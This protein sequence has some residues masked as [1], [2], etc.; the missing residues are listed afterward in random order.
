M[1]VAGGR[2]AAV[3]VALALVATGCPGSSN[4]VPVSTTTSQPS[5]PPSAI[6]GLWQSASEPGVGGRLTDVS[7][8]PADCGV[9]VVSGD[10][11]GAARSEDGGTSWEHIDGLS[12]REVSRVTWDPERP[13][14]VWIATMSGPFRSDD[15]GRSATPARAGMPAESEFSYTVPIETVLFDPDVEGRLLA[16]G[17]SHR[18]WSSPPDARWGVVW[19]STDDGATWREAGEVVPDGVILAAIH[20]GTG[21]LA[22]VDDAGVFR[23]DDGLTWTGP[24]AGLDGRTVSQFLTAGETVWAAISTDTSVGGIASSSDGGLTWSVD[25]DGIERS[26]GDDSGGATS[27]ESLAASA[28]G[29]IVYAGDVGYFTASVSARPESSPAWEQRSATADLPRAPYDS[30]LI[31]RALAVDPCDAERVLVGTDETLWL[32]EDGAVTWTDVS[33]TARGDESWTGRGFGGLVT[34]AA[35]YL[36]DGTLVTSSLDGGNLM[37]RRPDGSWHR[38][39]RRSRNFG[40]GHDVDARDERAI[41]AFGQDGFLD[42]LA[43]TTDSGSTWTQNEVADIEGFPE[44]GELPVAVAVSPEASWLVAVGGELWQ[45][46]SSTP[47]W[48]RSRRRCRRARRRR[49]R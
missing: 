36:G 22:S 2:G 40:G 16:F 28:D 33:A 31:A 30:G 19:E 45:A 20:T 18:R 14:V 23:S 27:F 26:D 21:W 46:R 4:D 13:D 37:L 34:T 6:P 25:D 49:V 7:F 29:S 15:G 43:V 35:A 12:G 42:A 11:L 8:D 1:S 44:A 48:S 32:S 47:T 3:A 17:G 5:V 39:L 9:M 10:L 38:P 24:V 41:V